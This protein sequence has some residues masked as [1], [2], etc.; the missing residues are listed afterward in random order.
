[1]D[2]VKQA[3][4]QV[5]AVAG[6]IVSA[7]ID[8]LLKGFVGIQRRAQAI[9]VPRDFFIAPQLGPGSATAQAF[10]LLA[11]LG[12]GAPGGID[13]RVIELFQFGLQPGETLAQI[14]ASGG[15]TRLQLRRENARR[16]ALPSVLRT[17]EEIGERESVL[18]E[19]PLLG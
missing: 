18:F 11:H 14:I 17:G 5:I 15:E 6:K 1:M 8:P 3:G 19:Q 12:A 16:Q 4:E 7:G 9:S 10:E 2:V 13:Q